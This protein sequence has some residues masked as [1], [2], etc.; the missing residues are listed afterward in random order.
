MSDGQ[1]FDAYLG[2]WGLTAD[3]A[4]IVTPSSSLL[5]VRRDGVPAMLKVAR[6]AEERAGAGLMVWWDGEGAARVLEHVGDALLMERA[7]GGTS[8][9][10]MARDGRDDE[11]S[12]ILVA[13][14]AG[15]HA[16]RGRPPPELVPL[17][18]W[19]RGLEPAARAHG[20]I[21]ARAAATARELLAAPRDV[22]VL[23]GDLHHFNVLDFGA[24]GWLAV[25][26]K[27]LVGERG[28]DFAN[29]FC[30]PDPGT[31]AAPGRLARQA[32]VVAAAAGLERGRLLQWVLAYAGLSAAWSLEDGDPPGAALAVA[33]LAAVELEA[34]RRI[35]GWWVGKGAGRRRTGGRR[36]CRPPVFAAGSASEPRAAAPARLLAVDGDTLPAAGAALAHGHVPHPHRADG[37]EQ[38][39]KGDALREVGAPRAH[40]AQ[41][42]GK[43]EQQRTMQHDGHGRRPARGMGL[44]E[45]RPWAWATSGRGLYLRERVRSHG[46]AY[47]RMTGVSRRRVRQPRMASASSRWKW[48]VPTSRRGE[49]RPRW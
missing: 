15:L 7:T 17:A 25:D 8:L 1:V 45:P 49:Y 5:P 14:A 23:H 41:V 16:P 19:F 33:E 39:G 20:G 29:L 6:A 36:T 43:P 48:W 46:P 37:S 2:R 18:R 9:A 40:L 24:R 32:H 22:T 27:G 21:L 26:P 10:A 28:F 11:A 42:H 47:R 38:P 35:A 31:A 3:G 30:N 13:A 44:R 34:R 4:P 12:R